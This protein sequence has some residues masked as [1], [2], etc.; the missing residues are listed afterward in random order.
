MNIKM[1]L[2]AIIYAVA[3]MAMADFD[4]DMRAA[5][6]LCKDKKHE[7]SIQ[8]CIKTGE[9]CKDPEQRYQ[10]FRDA[11]MCARLHLGGE[12]RG[13]EL[14]K[15][16]NVEPYAKACRAVV[17]QWQTSSPKVVA[18][19]ENED[20][21]EWPEDLAAIGFT[22]R[23]MAYYNLKNGQLASRDYLRAF[24]FAKG[25]EKWSALTKTW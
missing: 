4:A 11:A 22:V 2:I 16:I 8:A 25:F 3:V 12:A 9:A 24:Q 13:L 14:A 1:G 17:Y 23:G 5:A 6:A 15:Q 18:E 19:F 10:A 7:E 20:F 21:T